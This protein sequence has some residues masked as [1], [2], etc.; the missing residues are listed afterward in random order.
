ML[1]PG[2]L[3]GS[4]TISGPTKDSYGSMLELSWAGR[5]KVPVAH[6]EERVFLQDNDSV[7]MTGSA[8]EGIG[9]GE[10]RSGLL[11]AKKA[12]YGE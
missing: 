7:I 9:F 12:W 6:G 11:P 3:I 10:C 1:K 8:G 2:D 4:G 5:D